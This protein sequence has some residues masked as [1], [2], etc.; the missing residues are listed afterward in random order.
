MDGGG[1]AR[2][3]IYW[4]KKKGKRVRE[5]LRNLF[6]VLK[7]KEELRNARRSKSQ[8]K[9][10]GERVVCRRNFLPPWRRGF[11]TSQEVWFVPDQI[12]V[13]ERS[14]SGPCINAVAPIQEV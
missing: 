6:E 12:W 2:G 3:G 7:E 13:L 10:R 9:I 14:M 4:K 5:R 11:E 8:H 1:L